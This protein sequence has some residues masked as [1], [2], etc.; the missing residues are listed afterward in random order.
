IR[1]ANGDIVG[2]WY[3]GV[4]KGLLDAATRSLLAQMAIFS[5]TVLILASIAAW[6][7]AQRL[8]RPLLTLKKAMERAN[9]GDLTVA[10]S[11]KGRDEI[12]DVSRTFNQMLQNIALVIK[13]VTTSAGE[14]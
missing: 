10:C 12:A 14:L 6:F 1:N 7:F 9:T 4:S 11:V 13:Q 8:V 2:M 5:L 3:V